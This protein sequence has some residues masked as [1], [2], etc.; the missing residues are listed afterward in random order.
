[1]L[2]HRIRRPLLE[3]C[4]RWDRIS[5][6]IIIHRKIPSNRRRTEAFVLWQIPYHQT[7][8]TTLQIQARRDLSGSGWVIPGPCIRQEPRK[9]LY[10]FCR[11]VIKVTNQATAH[12]V[13]SSSIPVNH[14]PINMSVPHNCHLL[15]YRPLRPIQRGP[16]MMMGR[17]Y[18]AL[19][20][21]IHPEQTNL[22]T[23]HLGGGIRGEVQCV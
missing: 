10:G 8:M 23:G 6:I 2:I 5:S 7:H 15:I 14:N 20:P 19:Y 3:I 1:M 12:T 17:S 22:Q 16:K 4:Q 18:Q 11:N 13:T 9:F 21:L